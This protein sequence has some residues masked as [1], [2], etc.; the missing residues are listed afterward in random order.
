M[1]FNRNLGGRRETPAGVR[2][3]RSTSFIAPLVLLI[4]A[5]LLGWVLYGSLSPTVDN[6][7]TTTPVT[8][9][10]LPQAK[11]QPASPSPTTTP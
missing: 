6:T 4:A 1:A 3:P 10:D 8:P 11:P 5:A 2:T 9:T 7:G